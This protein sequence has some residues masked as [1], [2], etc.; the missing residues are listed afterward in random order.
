M[1]VARGL[2]RGEF[3]VCRT[4]RAGHV[5]PERGFE[6]NPEPDPELPADL[7]ALDATAR[8]ARPDERGDLPG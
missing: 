7:A 1:I 6:P 3:A 8:P 4:P 5:A 2:N